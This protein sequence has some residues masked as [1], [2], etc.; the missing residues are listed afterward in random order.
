MVHIHNGVLLSQLFLNKNGEKNRTGKKRRKEKQ[1]MVSFLQD[2]LSIDRKPIYRGIHDYTRDLYIHGYLSTE[3]VRCQSFKKECNYEDRIQGLDQ[4][5]RGEHSFT[6]IVIGREQM[7]DKRKQLHQLCFFESRQRDKRLIMI[8]LK[9]FG[10]APFWP[11]SSN[12]NAHQEGPQGAVFKK[13][14]VCKRFKG[15]VLRISTWKIPNSGRLEL[16]QVGSGLGAW[17]L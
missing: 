1:N 7:I 10:K 12:E 15:S 3:K 9:N 8:F 4:R 17:D 2:I 16:P 5:S 6:R 13:K 11:S 14:M